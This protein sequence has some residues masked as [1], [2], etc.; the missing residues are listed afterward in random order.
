MSDLIITHQCF[1]GSDT[2]KLLVTFD[3]YEIASYSTD[4]YCA[5]CGAYFGAPTPI[6]RP[7]GMEI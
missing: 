7:E 2:F 3:D 4:M 6:D 1:C 5:G